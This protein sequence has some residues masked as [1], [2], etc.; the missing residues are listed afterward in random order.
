MDILANKVMREGVTAKFTQN[1]Y[2]R[3]CLINTGDKN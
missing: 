2:L 1:L 3:Q